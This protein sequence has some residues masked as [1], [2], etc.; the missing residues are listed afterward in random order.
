LF[1]FE[2]L[3]QKAQEAVQQAQ[4]IAEKNQHQGLTP[5]HL[6]IALASEAEGIV[7]PVLEKCDAHPDAVVL[8]AERMLS[9]VPKVSGV[10]A[11][12]YISP[13]LNQVFERAFSEAEKFKDEFV[14]TEH[15]LVMTPS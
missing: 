6:L 14:S 5:L 15:L 2:K 9:G 1:R 11:G 12:M 13:A 7:R 4:S 3:T 10:G 8:E